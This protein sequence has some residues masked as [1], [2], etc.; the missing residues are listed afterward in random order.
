MT[1]RPPTSTLRDDLLADLRQAA[2]PAVPAPPQAA[3]P[4]PASAPADEASPSPSLDVR[5][6]WRPW[7]PLRLEPA[8]AGSGVV[9]T[10]GPLRLQ[11][12]FSRV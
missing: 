2:P 3:D 7:S 11:L 5:I 4:A 1:S 8:P 12:G 9:L 10:G 6:S